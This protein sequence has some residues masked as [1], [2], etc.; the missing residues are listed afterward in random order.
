M[1][2]K[3]GPRRNKVPEVDTQHLTDSLEEYVK[4]MGSSAA[5]VL[6]KYMDLQV[7]QAVSGPGLVDLVPLVK[8][9]H[10]VE[11]S[12][13][14]KY[15]DLVGSL[16]EVVRKFPEVKQGFPLSQQGNLPKILAERILVVCNHC[17]RIG[18]DKTKFQ[19]ASNKLSFYQLERLEELAEL[20][21][22]E[23]GERKKKSAPLPVSAKKQKLESPAKSDK[24]EATDDLLDRY[25]VPLS[26][27]SLLEEAREV[28]PLPPRKKALREAVGQVKK[29]PSMKRPSCSKGSSFT[30]KEGQQK[31][32]VWS[33]EKINFMAYKKTG[34]MALRLSGGR[35]LL[36]IK[37]PKGMKHSQELAAE[38]LSMLKAGKK[39]SV[40]QAWKQRQLEK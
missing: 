6:G 27:D 32:F 29:K 26:Q 13:Q 12:L 22:A 35:Q 14:F 10:K 1:S 25:Q 36:Q 31:D 21:G 7:Q 28:E 39:L 3:G 24:S 15:S 11:Q 37:S 40:V 16:K 17:R 9:L 30:E 33:N 2:K 8:A 18:A 38:A 5:F 4:A 20:G 19:Q 23:V 34:A